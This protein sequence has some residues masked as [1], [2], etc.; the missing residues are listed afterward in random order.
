MKNYILLLLFTAFLSCKAQNN[1]PIKKD[2]LGISV[3]APKG[4][5]QYAFRIGEWETAYKALIS[6]HEWKTGTGK[7]KV[8]VA[9]NGLTFVE[10]ATDEKGNL[11]H[12]IT[13]DY[14]EATDSWVNNYTEFE[15]GK[16]VQYTSKLVNGAMVETVKAD[17]AIDSITYALLDNN[18]FLYTSKR[19]YGNGFS[20][21]THAEVATK[22]L[23]N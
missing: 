16:K 12:K 7:H 15:T 17:E 18:I 4:V 1:T 11:K 8:Y 19:T 2:E 22:R 13:Y 3:N 10:E 20:I 5:H 23:N 21:V 6:R 9:E 14:I